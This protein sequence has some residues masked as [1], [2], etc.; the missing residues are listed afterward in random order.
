V[1]DRD[2]L[3]MATC[4]LSLSKGAASTGA[5]L[6]LSKGSAHITRWPC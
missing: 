4:A 1:I 6:S 3:S 5:V 2:L